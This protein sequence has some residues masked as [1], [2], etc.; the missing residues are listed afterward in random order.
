[1]T[2]IDYTNEFK[3]NLRQ[4]SRR[5]RSIRQYIDPVIEAL[6]A[7]ETPGDQVRGVGYSVFKLRVKNSDNNK[8]KSGGYRVIYYLKTDTHATLVTVYSK[9]DQSD[10][11]NP[12]LQRILNDYEAGRT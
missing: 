9:S 7:G 8:G 11:D 5:Y 12:T 3:R 10:V 2:E 6:R 4:L 1:V